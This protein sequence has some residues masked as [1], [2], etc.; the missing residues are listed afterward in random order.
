[1]L[2]NLWRNSIAFRRVIAALSV[3]SLAMIA[4]LASNIPQSASLPNDAINKLATAGPT[5]HLR[6]YRPRI[7][8][9]DPV[10]SFDG[11]ANVNA[12]VWVDDATL[13][14]SSV[15]FAPLAPPDPVRAVYAEGGKAVGKNSKDCRTMLT[16]RRADHSSAPQ[17]LDLWQDGTEND[18]QRF[19]QVIISS[20]ETALV[21]EVSTNSPQP[22]AAMC[23]RVLTMGK[24]TI[25]IPGGPVY[26]L[27]P[28]DKAITLLFSSID[29][30]GFTKDNTFDDLSLGAGTLTADG[31]D[32]ASTKKP[33]PAL[34]H[35]LVREG[36]NG[37]TLHDLK[38]GA[39]EVSLSVGRDT[40]KAD[41]W[42]NGKRLL[43]FDLVD[44]IQKN[45][46]LSSLLAAVLIPGLWVWIK[47]TCLPPKRKLQKRTERKA[48][49]S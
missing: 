35:V 19:R 14:G 9:G 22:A 17:T 20:P 41:A 36:T 1:M 23:P 44:T 28:A 37:I 24:T 47:K 29:S 7:E 39:E 15:L 32:V 6:I 11:A 46:V 27:A 13:T 25:P 21:V 2:Q 3:G 40:E 18:Q 33:N 4:Y 45:P 26:L 10:L 31:F 8:V 5:E 16:I 49:E 43:V 34:L 12:E 30:S 42:T 48:E 38:L